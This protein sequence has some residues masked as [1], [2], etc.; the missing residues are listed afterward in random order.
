MW[1]RWNLVVVHGVVVLVGLVIWI[2]VAGRGL[3]G[4]VVT[5]RWIGVGLRVI[6]IAVVV[7]GGGWI[8]GGGVVAALVHVR[9]GRGLIGVDW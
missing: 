5:W 8:A 7:G 2:E 1:R 9:V 3:L 4:V 6:W